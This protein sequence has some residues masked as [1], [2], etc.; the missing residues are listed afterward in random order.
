VLRYLL[1]ALTY[2]CLY[3]TARRW[4]RDGRLQALAV[5]SFALIYVFAYYAHHDL[6]HTT[7]LGA[8]V[9]ATYAA[10]AHLAARPTTPRYLL[11]GV[12]L[13]LGMLAKWNFAMLALGLP[14]TCLL[15]PGWRALLLTW[16]TLLALAV[17]ALLVAPTALWVFEH[18]R[19]VVEVSSDILLDDGLSGGDGATLLGTILAGLGALL[20][21]ALVF[22][23]PF[24][25][26]FL[27]IFAR[28]LLRAVKAEHHGPLRDPMRFMGWLM[29]V[30]LGLHLLLVPLMGAT[31]FTERWMHPTLMIL[32]LFLFALL[33]RG[34]PSGRAPSARAMVIYLAVIALLVAG[35]GGARLYRFL[36]GAEQCGKCRELAPF[37][38]LAD[39]LRAA[40][41]ER[42]TII[43]DGFHIGGNL[44][45][46]FP[47][48]RVV[49]PAFPPALWPPAEGAGMCLSV[50]Q[51]DQPGAERRRGFLAR[52]RADALGVED[53][54]AAEYGRLEAMMYGARSRRYA[55]GF[56]LLREGGHGCR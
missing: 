12:C 18:G 6:T 5:F 42:G 23:Q 49:D 16:K 35:A 40:G 10:F 34:A 36:A 33:E 17:M 21:A 2:G 29:L 27:A 7:A 37:A 44:K 41:F 3:L 9:A 19:T 56:E 8:M 31:A 39:Q 25:P 43:A 38:E 45:M 22:P 51:E 32:P 55:L 15:L 20:L 30:I 26:L 13:G 46:Q 47:D 52:C 53:V 11:L 1:L 4:I 48:S 24:L 50:W 28:P 14:L 54:D